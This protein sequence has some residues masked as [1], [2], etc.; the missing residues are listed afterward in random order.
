MPRTTFSNRSIIALAS[1]ACVLGACGKPATQP[2]STGGASTSANAQSNPSPTPTP[3]PISDAKAEA[4]RAAPGTTDRSWILEQAMAVAS[5]IPTK[6]H[7]RER[8]QCQEWVALAYLDAG[9]PIAAAR[10]AMH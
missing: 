4:P 2:E 6:I 3:A 5:A 8:A 7:D 10:C 1:M 9:D